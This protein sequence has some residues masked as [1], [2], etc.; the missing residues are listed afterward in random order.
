MNKLQGFYRGKVIKRS[1]SKHGY[2]KIYIP[3]V[4]PEDSQTNWQ[5]LPDAEPAMPLFAGCNNGNG[6]FSYPNIGSIV[7]C[8]FMN[9]DQN[10]PVYFAATYGGPNAGGQFATC[11]QLSSDDGAYLHKIC[12]GKSTVLLSEEGYISIEVHNINT[13]NEEKHVTIKMDQSGNLDICSNTSMSFQSNS[14]DIKARDKLFIQS[15]DI[16]IETNTT[17]VSENKFVLKSDSILEDC[18]N[19]YFTTVSKVNGSKLI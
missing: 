18:S 16:E 6:M 7:W 12:A 17:G 5:L 13:N 10:L 1:Q 9:G 19:G 15:P 4:Y 8:F 3:G 14:I 11:E 2:L